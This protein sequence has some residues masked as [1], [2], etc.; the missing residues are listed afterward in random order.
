MAQL[1]VKLSRASPPTQKVNRPSSK[2]FSWLVQ[3]TQ[4]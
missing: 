3:N 2:L 1:Q 4:N